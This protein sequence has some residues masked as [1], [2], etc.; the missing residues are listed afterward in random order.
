MPPKEELA[1]AAAQLTK[2]K[3]SRT[4]HR[5]KITSRCN[6]IDADFE[7]FDLIDCQENLEILKEL[8]SKHSD[9]NDAIVA[10]FDS[11]TESSVFETELSASE[12]YDERIRSCRKKLKDRMSRELLIPPDPNAGLGGGG[13][14]TSGGD[15]KPH[16]LKLPE[17][18]LPFFHHEEGQ[19]FLNFITNFEDIINKYSLSDFEK[20][21][22]LERQLKG[23]PLDLIKD[24]TGTK[25]C[26]TGAKQLLIKAFGRPTKQ[27]FEI[28]KDMKN[29]KFDYARPY[30]FISSIDLIRTSIDEQKVEV[31]TVL[32]Y[33][34]WYALPDDYQTELIHLSGACNPSVAQILEHMFDAVE[35][36]RFRSANKVVDSTS[37]AAN[38]DIST[39]PKE[40]PNHKSTNPK[41][42][43]PNPKPSSPNPKPSSPNTNTS[44]PSSKS[45]FRGCVLCSGESKADHTLS[46]CNNFPTAKLKVSKLKELNLCI[47]CSGMHSS[48][49][50]KFNFRKPCF[51]CAKTNHFSFLCFKE[52][53]KESVYNGICSVELLNLS[54]K[55]IE[56]NML[57]TFSCSLSNN[58]TIRVLADSG[59]E[60]SFIS[61]EVIENYNYE[62]LENDVKLSI[63]G[64]NSLRNVKT[65]LV[66]LEVLIGNKKCSVPAVIIPNISASPKYENLNEITQILHERGYETADEF[67]TREPNKSVDMILGIDSFHLLNLKTKSFGRCTD[68][69]MFV[70]EFGVMPIGNSDK[71]FQNLKFLPNLIATND[72]VQISAIQNDNSSF[73]P[74]MNPA[75]EPCKLE[76]NTL[77][78]ACDYGPIEFEENVQNCDNP[79][80]DKLCTDVIEQESFDVSN[81]DPIIDKEMCAKVLGQIKE[82]DQRLEVP[83]IWHENNSDKLA[84]NFGLCRKV[85]HGI[86][87]KFS[88]IP[89]GLETIDNVFKEQVKQNI[90]EPIDDLTLFMK[91]N[92]DCKF[93]AHTPVMKPSSNTTKCR[94]VYM[95]NLCEKGKENALSHNQTIVSGPQL[96]RPIATA[97]TL[98]RFDENLVI[99]DL[100]KAFLQLK[101]AEEDQRKLCFLWFKDIANNDFALIGYK[102]CRLP[103]GLRCSPSI[104]MLSLYYI[105]VYSSN[106]DC[107]KDFKRHVYDLLFMDNGGISSHESLVPLIPKLIEVFKK[108]GFELQEFHT[109][110]QSLKNQYPDLFPS[111]ETNAK[112]LGMTWDSVQDTIS[113]PKFNLDPTAKT[114]R[115]ILSSIAANFDLI[116]IGG[117]MLN[118][119]RLFMQTLQNERDL[120]WDICLSTSWLSTWKNICNQLNNA[121]EVSIPRYVGNR[122]SEFELLAYVDASKQI[123][124]AVLYLREISTG[125]TSF[126]FSKNRL[127]N[128]TLAEKSIPTLE[129]LA[130]DFGTKLL[131][132]T[133]DELAGPR[134]MNPINV[135]ALKLFTDSTISLSWIRSHS[136]LFSK[137]NKHPM[138]I[139]NR[140]KS[141][142][143]LCHIFPITFSHTAGKEN[144]ADCTTRCL[145]HKLLSKTSYWTGPSPPRP[146]ETGGLAPSF[147]FFTVPSPD[148]GE[149]DVGAATVT[150]V[151]NRFPVETNRFASHG[152]LVKVYFRVLTFINRLKSKV[153]S[154]GKFFQDL[155]LPTFENILKRAHTDIIR[156]DQYEHFPELHEYFDSRESKLKNIPNLVTQLNIFK[157]NHG[158]LRVKCKLSHIGESMI[159]YP[160][161]LSKSSNLTKTI[162]LDAHRDLNHSGKYS[163]LSCLKKE[164]YVPSFFSVVRKILRS[165]VT[166][167][168]LNER[169][170][171]TNQNS[172]RDFRLH[173]SNVPFRNVFVDFLGY[174]PIKIMNVQS[175]V[176]LL[177][178]T[179]LYSRAINLV[180]CQDLS[181]KS[182][183]RACQLHVFRWGLPSIL[184]S[185]SGSQIIAGT[186]IISEHLNH[187]STKEYLLDNDIQSLEFSNYPKGKNELGGIV[188]ICVKMVKRL[189]NSSIGNNVLTYSEFEFFI[190]EANHIVNRRPISFLESVRDS[191]NECPIPTP[192]TPEMI[193]HGYELVTANIIPDLELKEVEWTPQSSVNMYEKLAK[194]RKRMLDLYSDELIS[195][196]VKQSTNLPNRY[197]PKKHTKL[198]VGDL[199]LIKEQFTK[200]AHLPMAIVRDIQTNSLGEVTAVTLKKGNNELVTRHVSSLIPILESEVQDATSS[201][202]R[203][204]TSTVESASEVPRRRGPERAA[205][206]TCRRR[207]QTLAQ[208]GSV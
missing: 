196:L 89:D 75:N 18:P 46:K 168:K 197:A 187:P 181:V 202:V 117:P 97:L 17:M 67:V 50:C 164:F 162:I 192:L 101:L 175:K 91:E 200:R 70:S 148:S 160:I 119:A 107:D 76:L 28:I 64:F 13:L 47:K 62:V 124:G 8:E 57:P 51:F 14:R 149:I 163:V 106:E 141:I 55:C 152:K 96:N 151:Q 58:E 186:K 5:G 78:I 42:G 157:D 16:K 137:M 86:K 31:E 7:Q 201:D 66:K 205:A 127:L 34:I 180:I 4:F 146:D 118:R 130:I 9:F 173:P 90:I 121:P 150:P 129:L 156:N 174:F 128:K 77:F 37:F 109:N 114:K 6:A 72:E 2:L 139:I 133:K 63:K 183:L 153:K 191:S 103:F 54:T 143:K 26:Y 79:N 102:C 15:P 19:S 104:L 108:F 194:V 111:Q 53:G 27:K 74:E 206:T 41:F 56:K 208:Q 138:F 131:I 80:L 61:S 23:E 140:L 142:D 10:E 120:G 35:R 21:V 189:L 24:L 132:D 22:Y 29:L 115:T 204:A 110:D 60:T 185:D 207:C 83:I 158:I 113:P 68:S 105:L 32:Q 193:I 123:Y 155:S 184:L 136:V 49:D 12:R 98:L 43:A 1:A 166:C 169:P 182:F 99:Y 190:S 92:K 134:T 154:K 94:V 126:L 177:L 45:D 159:N 188:E 172:Y 147:L 59:A 30:K 52:A 11:E 100:K 39:K 170:I 25:R 36:I 116:N 73:I 144:P 65:K 125:K 40:P 176:Y 85:L 203:D 199:V 122:D 93:L 69:C 135:T 171:Q 71:F 44:S 179:C 165:C 81:A 38:I 88:K 167:R 161:L 48:R 87:S 195:T 20:F 84:Q 95:A 178:F 112:L 145:S 82:V 3:N 198:G 33:F